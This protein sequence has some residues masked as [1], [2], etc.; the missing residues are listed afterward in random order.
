MKNKLTVTIPKVI[1]SGDR[2]HY[3]Q[4]CWDTYGRYLK[5]RNGSD[6][7][8]AVELNIKFARW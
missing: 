5:D 3:K 8:F 1:W 2:E 6:Q 7:E 4:W